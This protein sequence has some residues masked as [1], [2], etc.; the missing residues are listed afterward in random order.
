MKVALII[1][2]IFL[3]G[4]IGLIF[5]VECADER[6]RT[7]SR[8]QTFFLLLLS[9]PIVWTGYLLFGLG[10]VIRRVFNWFYSLLK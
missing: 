4:M 5:S 7:S 1:L 8:K 6:L 3:C 10:C 9:G 2:G